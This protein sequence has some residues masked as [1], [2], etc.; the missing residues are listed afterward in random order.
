MMFIA[1]IVRLTSNGSI[2]YKQT[3]VGLRERIFVIYKFRTMRP[4]CSTHR[5]TLENDPR[6]TFIGKWLR[7]FRLDELPQ[8]INVIKGDMDMV[9]PRPEQEDVYDYVCRHVIRYPARTIVRP[10]ITGLSQITLPYDRTL[11]DVRKK[12]EMDLTY[13]R[14]KSILLDVAIMLQT[15]AV[16]MGLK[17]KNSAL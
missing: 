5:W 12:L 1:I 3:R 14:N 13:I 11:D 6:V 15:P 16:M 8:L 10:G 7:K 2:I 9:G 4:G 17:N